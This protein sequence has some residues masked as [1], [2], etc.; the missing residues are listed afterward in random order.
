MGSYTSKKKNRPPSQEDKPPSQEAI[1]LAVL[2]FRRRW[3]VIATCFFWH[4]IPWQCLA[5]QQWIATRLQC[6]TNILRTRWPAVEELEEV[7]DKP[8]RADPTFLDLLMRRSN[9]LLLRRQNTFCQSIFQHLF[10]KL[11][12]QPPAQEAKKNIWALHVYRR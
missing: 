10:V 8:L 2:L 12:F 9:N 11:V 6:I 5:S 1:M 7:E 4:P 3:P